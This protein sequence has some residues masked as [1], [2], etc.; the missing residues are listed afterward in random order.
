MNKYS[1]VDY[2]AIAD[3]LSDEEKLV[4]ESIRDFVSADV[5]PIIEEHYQ[6]SSFPR[7]LVPKLGELGVFGITLPEKYGCPNLNNICYGLAMQELERGDSGLRSFAS[8]Q[9]SLVMYPIFTFGSE[10]QK[11]KWLP[12]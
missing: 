6:K 11:N 1:G 2:F 3:L 7:E 8:V 9:S 10:N 5:I 12:S 4:Q